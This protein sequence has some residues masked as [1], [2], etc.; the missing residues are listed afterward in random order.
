MNFNDAGALSQVDFAAE[1]VKKGSTTVGLRSATHAVI[2]S[3]NVSAYSGPPT[4]HFSI[5]RTKTQL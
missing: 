5:I 2:I 3:I 4:K 1:A